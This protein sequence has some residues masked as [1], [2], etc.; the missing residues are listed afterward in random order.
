MKKNFDASF[1]EVIG[2]EG[3]FQNDRDDLGNWT[4]GRVGHGQLRGT[5]YGVSAA[6]YPNLD[7]QSLTLE[8]AKTIYKRDYWD[9]ARCDELPDGVDFLVFDIAINHGLKDGIRFLQKSVG[10]TAD[11]IIGPRT[12][13]AV[14]FNTADQTIRDMCMIRSIDYARMDHLSKY[15]RGW[16]RRIVD[17]LRF[18]DK[19]NSSD[20]DQSKAVPNDVVQQEENKSFLERL[21]FRKV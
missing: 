15:W 3:G 21:G 20:L 10:A 9:K 7:I 18:A 11:G 14:R 2:S 1:E 6:S 16:F 5:K 8:D 12:M 4:G 17:T 13:S 19:L